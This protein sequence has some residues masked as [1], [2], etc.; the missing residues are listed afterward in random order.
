M[1]D[2]VGQFRSFED[3]LG[4]LSTPDLGQLLAHAGDVVLVLDKD[5]EIL[6]LSFGEP[7]SKIE[8]YEK[9]IG[10]S[11]AD[12]V[13]PDS[14]PKVMQMLEDTA[15]GQSPRWRQLNHPATPL[16]IPVQYLCL[17]A[18]KDHRIIAIG[19]DLRTMSELQQRLVKAQQVMEE[20]YERYRQAETRYRVL[21]QMAGEAVLVVNAR[22]GEISEANAAAARLLASSA[23]DL[24]GT[25]LGQCISLKDT[26]ALDQ[27]MEEVTAA[28][29]VVETHIHLA[30]NGQRCTLSARLFNQ[31]AK[32]FVF[33][34]V[35][36]EAAGQAMTTTGLPIA[37]DNAVDRLPDG[38]VMTDRDGIIQQCNQAF[39]AMTQTGSRAQVI[40]NSFENWLWQPGLGLGAMIGNLSKQGSLRLFGTALRGDLGETLS[41]EISAVV[42]RDQAAEYYVFVV[43]DVGRRI[44]TG[45][46]VGGDIRGAAENMT[47]LVGRVSLKEIVREATDVIE[48]LCIESALE[49]TKDNR[50]SAAEMLGLSRQ[51]LY[52][53]MRR[54]GIGESG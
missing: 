38:F 9:W 49:M 11:W 2:P 32:P 26:P 51:S 18:G 39:I 12:V 13:A 33:I 24:I 22:S 35:L 34:R 7:G 16:D 6:D 47:E 44:G 20:D 15:S 4:A 25:A 31:D 10:Q 23:S 37:L 43:R 41:V 8:G 46:E 17:P 5:G 48:R 54:F 53:K 19:R 14:R 27:L 42:L 36:P 40:G 30:Q 1:W 21:F 45:P 50:A 28:G 52:V 3:V 29:G